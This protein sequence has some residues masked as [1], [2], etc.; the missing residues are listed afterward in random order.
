[1]Y[2]FRRVHASLIKHTHSPHLFH[3]KSAFSLA[4]YFI[5]RVNWSNGVLMVEVKPIIATIEFQLSYKP[6]PTQRIPSLLKAQRCQHRLIMAIAS[7]QIQSQL[8]VATVHFD[9]V[10]NK[11]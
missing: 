8:G 9:I 5:Y 11:K 10:H 4:G 3:L 2:L 1:M 7:R 6:A